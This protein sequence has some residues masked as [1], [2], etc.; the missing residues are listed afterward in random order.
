VWVPPSLSFLISPPFLFSIYYLPNLGPLPKNWFTPLAPGLF[1]VFRFPENGLFFFFPS[2]FTVL[3]F[4]SCAFRRGNLPSSPFFF[5]DR[6][7]SIVPQS[8]RGKCDKWLVLDRR[9]L[10]LNKCQTVLFFFLAICV[11][12]GVFFPPYGQQPSTNFFVFRGMCG[13]S[14]GF[15]FFFSLAAKQTLALFPPLARGNFFCRHDHPL[16]FLSRHRVSF[17]FPNPPTRREISTGKKRSSH[18]SLLR[19][20]ERCVG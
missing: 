14:T 16:F 18:P 1:T 20:M 8:R 9:R 7:G 15:S 2:S 10:F 19:F 6:A 11:Q 4:F 3:L 5:F 13:S 17:P 12:A